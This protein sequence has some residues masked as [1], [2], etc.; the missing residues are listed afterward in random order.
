MKAV[1]QL[2]MLCAFV[3]LSACNSDAP[4]IVKPNV[5]TSSS[6]T[7]TPT[8]SLTN[9]ATA[10]ATALIS[11]SIT[12]TLT[13]TP[14]ATHTATF[15]ATASE[16]PTHTNTPTESVTLTLTPSS[17]STA[18]ATL[19][20]TP[21]ASETATT[22]PTITNTQT[23]TATE[24][25]T[26]TITATQTTTLTMTPT[27]T[28]TEIPTTTQT[29]TLT[30]TPT[31][32]ITPTAT[33]TETPTQTATLTA[34]PTATATLSLTPTLTSTATPTTPPTL[35]STPTA[36]LTATPTLVPSTPV[37]TQRLLISEVG[38]GHYSNSRLWFEIYNG[39]EHTLN[40][41]DY[42]FR[43]QARNRLTNVVTEDFTFSLPNRELAAND[44]ILIARDIEFFV[45]SKQIINIKQNDEIP[46]WWQS[47]FIELL[48]SDNSSLDFIRFGSNNSAPTNSDAWSGNNAELLF[49]SA[50]ESAGYSLRRDPALT[51][52]NTATDWTLSKFPTPRGD[53][54]VTCEIDDDA[55]GIPDCSEIEGSTY[56]G[57]DLYA[58]GARL[59]QKD[60]FLEI[61]YMDSSD[62]GITPRKEALQKVKAAFAAKGFAL[63]IDVGS[64]YHPAAGISPNDFDL[65]GGNT[66]PFQY[67]LSLSADANITVYELKS[68]YFDFTRKQI[69]HYMVFGSTQDN[70]GLRGS[71]GYAEV[72]GS[73]SIVT[74]GE[75]GLNSTSNSQTNRLINFQAGT[76]MHE[77]GH[78][79]NLRHGGDSNINDK[80][81]YYSVM[82]Y[83]YQ[84]NG[85]SVIGDQEGDRYYW[86][87]FGENGVC[88]NSILHNAYGSYFD[89]RIDYS[90][91]SAL[92]LNENA[93][94]EHQGLGRTGSGAVDFNC[95]GIIEDNI[96][97]DS[98]NDGS[99]DLVSDYNDWGNIGLL[100]SH[101][102]SA[103]HGATEPE[104]MP[105]RRQSAMFYQQE[106]IQEPVPSDA[107]FAALL[108]ED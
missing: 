45:D 14:T 8:L 3:I 15:T 52:S 12:T 58:L 36:S 59:N 90:D 92:D 101:K 64:L 77:L 42:K 22:T 82:N 30:S 75:W 17:I 106:T 65:G 87:R 98:N 38:S 105:L 49:T 71:S 29:A 44:Y 51:D 57:F 1:I 56:A 10:S 99:L 13:S 54:D 21:T 9:T 63:H 16:T 20:M 74:L 53:N 31:L 47:G 41:Q 34:T 86:S 55:D 103:N 46:N 43:S 67:G 89:F 60:I 79:L 78:N 91:G 24:T 96:S 76:L 6:A 50:D 48:D 19:T 2:V 39:T 35:S 104:S 84:L 83:L 70:S 88:Y 81:N 27:A 33:E 28:A 11:P 100:F 7:I 40:L 25:S 37:K 62:E 107:F 97:F 4:A 18:T 102:W 69:F 108:K 85:L 61:D 73:D 95:N 26:V 94:N 5:A 80:A 32:T 23:A 68:Q 66:V 93:L 72:Y